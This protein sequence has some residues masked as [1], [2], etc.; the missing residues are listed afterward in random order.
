MK[1]YKAN[2]GDL[3]YDEMPKLLFVID[4]HML[5]TDVDLFQKGD[6]KGDMGLSRGSLQHWLEIQ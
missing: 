2:Y 1:D 6:M 5:T 3:E 4:S